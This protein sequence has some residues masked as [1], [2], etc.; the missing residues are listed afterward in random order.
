MRY[1]YREPASGKA[2]FTLIEVLVVV[3]I[4]GIL[5]AF[6]APSWLNLLERNRLTTSRDQIYSAIRQTQ[7]TAQRQGSTWQ[8]SVRERNDFVEWAM[9]PGAVAPVAASWE[10][11]DSASVQIDDET[12]FESLGDVHYVRFDEAGNVANKLGRITLSSK[13]APTIKRCVIVSTIIGAMRKSKEQPV[14][15]NGKLCY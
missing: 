14:P 2:G 15:E 13:P 9:H 5:S 3:A 4:V 12:T 1:Q 8:F 10:V 7:V 11:L 6:T